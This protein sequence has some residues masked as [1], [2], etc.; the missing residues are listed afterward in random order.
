MDK[1]NDQYDHTA[2]HHATWM[3]ESTPGVHGAV[4]TDPQHGSSGTGGQDL[5]GYLTSV[6]DLVGSSRNQGVPGSPT[7]DIIEGVDGESAMFHDTTWAGVE[8][9]VRAGEYVQWEQ[10]LTDSVFAVE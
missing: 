7:A 5:N 8:R 2:T 3:C 9:M 10:H 1:F 6:D 4:R